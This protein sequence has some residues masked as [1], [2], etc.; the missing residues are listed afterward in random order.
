VLLIRGLLLSTALPAVIAAQSNR[1][2]IPRMPLPQSTARITATLDMHFD[3]SS[4]ALPTP[5]LME[6]TSM[7][8]YVRRTGPVDSLG[9]FSAQLD[10]DTLMTRIS[11]N[12]TPMGRPMESGGARATARYDSAGALVDLTV[13]PELERFANSIRQLQGAML[14]SVPRGTMAVGDSLVTPFEAPVPLDIGMGAGDSV[15]LEGTLTHRLRAIKRDSGQVVAVFDQVLVAGVNRG[16][17]MPALGAAQL[18]LRMTGTG[19]MEIE[20]QR[21]LVRSASSDSKVDATMDIGAGG[22]VTMNGT[23]RTTSRGSPLP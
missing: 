1:V 13:P 5:I 19:T 18:S 11:L 2:T 4:P 21:G 9:G 23:I 17:T 15:A 10:Y 14:T 16:I 6:G 20:V 12:G 22:T 8:Q 3:V 7:A